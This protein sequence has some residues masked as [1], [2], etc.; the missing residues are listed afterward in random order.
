MTDDVCRGRRED[1]GAYLLGALD[2]D[3][4]TAL[5]AHL[6]GCADCRAEANA[7]EPVARLLPLADPIRLSAQPAPPPRLAKSIVDRVIAEKRTTRLRRARR[8]AAG[9]IVAAAVITGLL[10][11]AGVTGTSGMEV[12][13]S[14]AASGVTSHAVLE[15]LPGG[16][17]IELDIDGLP[18]EQVYAVWLEEGDGSRVPAGTFWM[19]EDERLDLSMTA[20]LRLKECEGIGISNAEGKTVMY[21][22]LHADNDE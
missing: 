4:T 2:A 1:I 6:D 10:I 18:T 3:R 5:I 16:T 11:Y 15:Y 17:H 9:T 14:N 12:N 13:L 7:L 22:E 21:S 20:A 19:P 8:V